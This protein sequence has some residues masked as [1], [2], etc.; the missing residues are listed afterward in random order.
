VRTPLGKRRGPSSFRGEKRGPL[1]NKHHVHRR[2]KRGERG[3]KGKK[4]GMA[5]VLQ[6]GGGKG[7]GPPRKGSPCDGDAIGR[8][9][10][11]EGGSR[12]SS[13]RR[14]G[15][16]NALREKKDR[17]SSPRAERREK[18]EKRGQKPVD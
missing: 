9:K 8:K 7:G 10:G 5:S 14:Q 12:L 15:G 13:S 11:G 16:K 3:R 1:K 17:Q 2:A 4:E 6:G 18:G